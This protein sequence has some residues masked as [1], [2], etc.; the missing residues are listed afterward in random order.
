M[1]IIVQPGSLVKDEA[2]SSKSESFSGDHALFVRS[3]CCQIDADMLPACYRHIM[4]R[5]D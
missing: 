3:T 4:V 5:P 1:K 2:E